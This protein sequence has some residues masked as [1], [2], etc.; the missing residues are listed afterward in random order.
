MDGYV[1]WNTS[2]LCDMNRTYA[3]IVEGRLITM[4]SWTKIS[5]LNLSSL[6]HSKKWFR[7][8][9]KKQNKKTFFS[10]LITV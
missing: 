5:K 6:S 1:W 8:Y 9:L 10:I 7:G 4:K 3:C 2:L